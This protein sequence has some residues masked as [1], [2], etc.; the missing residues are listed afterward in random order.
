LQLFFL[1]IFCTFFSHF[2]TTFWCINHETS[3]VKY[4]YRLWNLKYVPLTVKHP[5]KR[6]K[7]CKNAKKK[8]IKCKKCYANSMHITCISINI[9]SWRDASQVM[10]GKVIGL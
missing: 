1:S 5:P 7:K 8:I 3:T 2:F 10:L 6:W 9:S 4:Y